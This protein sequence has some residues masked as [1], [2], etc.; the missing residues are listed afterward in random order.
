MLYIFFQA[1]KSKELEDQRRKEEEERQQR[2]ELERY[3][4]S[5]VNLINTRGIFNVKL[6][7]FSFEK[8]MEGR[9]KRR[10]RR[11]RSENTEE[12]FLSRHK[13][14]LAVAV[15]FV[16]VGASAAMYWL[17]NSSNN[18]DDVG[19]VDQ[20]DNSNVLVDNEPNFVLPDEEATVG[21]AP[22]LEF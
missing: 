7:Y 12:S 15:V 5:F 1:A 8:K 9:R 2:E 13:F 10:D 20:E 11:R 22:N 21:E 19:T 3:V 16:A 18:N 6:V 17:N 14:K 4:V